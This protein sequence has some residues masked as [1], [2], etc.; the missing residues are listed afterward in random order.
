MSAPIS[1]TL[2]DSTTAPWIAY[3]TGTA[4]FNKDV[5][6]Y[7][8]LAIHTGFIHLDGAQVYGNEETLG[9]GILASGK[10]RSEL[11]VTTK[12]GRLKAGETV[13]EALQLSLQNL[14]LDYVDQYLI[15]SPT[16]HPEPGRLKQLW[17]EMEGVKIDG[18]TRY[19]FA[20]CLLCE[21]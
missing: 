1:I 19:V 2:N 11:Y 5:S 9:K 16:H 3:G 21:N 14:G 20:S 8:E 6:Q 18:L 15:H 7:I 17:K 10:L 4:L 13:K 12:L